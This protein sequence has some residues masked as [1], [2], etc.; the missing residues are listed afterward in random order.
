MQYNSAVASFEKN[1]EFFILDFLVPQLI[2]RQALL[3][4]AVKHGVIHHTLVIRNRAPFMV[5][6]VVKVV[7]LLKRGSDKAAHNNKGY[8]F[9]VFA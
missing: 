2:E 4:E 5:A 1:A 6:Q 7:K 9:T 8:L 3:S